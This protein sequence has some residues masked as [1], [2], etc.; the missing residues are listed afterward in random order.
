V[1][2]RSGDLLGSLDSFETKLVT[3]ADTQAV[4][5]PPG[6]LLFM[7]QGFLYA[8]GFDAER[9]EPAGDPVR[10]ADSVAFVWDGA[11]GGFSVSETGMLAYRQAGRDRHRLI[12]YDRSGKE[13]NA[14]GTPDEN[15]LNNA[16]LSSNGRKA[17]VD[18]YVRENRDIYMIDAETG[19]TDR[20]TF[21]PAAE[22]WAVWSPDGSQVIFTSERTNM[23]DLY[24]KSSS[25]GKEEL[26]CESPLR[27][28]PM[29]WSPDGRHFLY[30]DSNPKTFLDIWVK[31]LFGDGKPFEFE[32]TSYEEGD[33]QF[34]PDGRWVAYQS[35]QSGTFE[36]WVKA[37]P[38]TGYKQQ[39]TDGGGIEARWNGNGKELFYI[40][41]D[42]KMMAIPIQAGGQSLQK[43]SPIAL[44][45]T[46]IVQGGDPSV[47]PKQQYAVTRDGQR[48][49]INTIVD[50]STARPITIVTN[51][52]RALRK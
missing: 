35:N 21:D 25:G 14:L 44:F 51:W 20:F 26:F 5:A 29:D 4:Y 13:T 23:G 10:I 8:Q 16:E 9:G 50:E 47:H 18:R 1:G 33:A 27:K 43:G 45:Q 52:A 19:S 42:G 48:F 40:A 46:R 11:L 7:R 39:I 15:Q 2:I 28:F 3:K 12:W 38:D 22:G 32:K 36:I 6:Y 24:K 30:V 37:F 49:L 31:P 41:R 17:L 34:S